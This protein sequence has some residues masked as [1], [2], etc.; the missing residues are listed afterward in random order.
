LLLAG[1]T[2]TCWVIGGAHFCTRDFKA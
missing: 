2:I 1:L